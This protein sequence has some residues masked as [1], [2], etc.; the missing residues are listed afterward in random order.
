[1]RT[2]APLIRVPASG[3][4]ITS[5]QLA[6]LFLG[7]LHDPSLQF[8][9]ALDGL[10]RNRDEKIRQFGP[11]G[12]VLVSGLGPVGLL[13]LLES[14]AAGCTVIGME[15]RSQYTRTQIFRLTQDTVARI[16]AFTGDPVWDQLIKAG[17]SRGSP[18]SIRRS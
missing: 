6:S 12:R 10:Q 15:D 9:K 13:T 2:G 7:Y 3:E 4:D 8:G 16:R 14:Y 18:S 5:R 1:M 11:Q 17:G